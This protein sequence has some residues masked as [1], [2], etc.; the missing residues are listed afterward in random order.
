MDS[1]LYD[2]FHEVGMTTASYNRLFSNENGQEFEFAQ[3]A[4]SKT[5]ELNIAH[6]PKGLYFIEVLWGDNRNSSKFL[7]FECNLPTT[8]KISKAALEKA[9]ENVENSLANLT[10]ADDGGKHHTKVCCFCDRIIAHGCQSP[11]KSSF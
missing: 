10:Y 6:L 9:I 5:I 1:G 3:T 2:A 7:R 11:V 8:M 4:T